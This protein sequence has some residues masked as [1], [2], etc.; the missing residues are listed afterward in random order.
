V[1]LEDIYDRLEEQRRLARILM[2]RFLR[3]L[4]AWHEM[5]ASVFQL[6]P[7]EFRLD[8]PATR[9]QLAHAAERVVLI[10]QSTRA[11]LWEVLREGQ[12]RGY[13]NHEIAHGVPADGYGGIDGLYLNT[14]RGRSETIARTEVAEAQNVASLDR[15]AATG[16]VDRVQIV[17]HEDTD[18][19]CASRNGRV[20][21]LAS[22]PGLLHPNCQ[23]G[24][25][26]VVN[27]AAA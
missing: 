20:V 19:P 23:M 17:E 27:E 10:D 16:M 21:P 11:A 6:S 26:P 2:P 22:K 13:S 15:Y 12:Q 3:L 8:D 24:L 25:I 1:R 9:K 14:W 5:V 18:E 4:Q 7:E